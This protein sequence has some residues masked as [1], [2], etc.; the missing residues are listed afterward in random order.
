MI[1]KA[2]NILAPEIPTKLICFSDDMDALRKVPSNLPNQEVLHKSI[3]LSLTKVPD[4]YGTASSFGANMNKRLIAFLTKFNF[5]FEFASSSQYYN[6]G[7]FNDTLEK[8]LLNYEEINNLIKNTLGTERREEYS[9]FMPICPASG[10]VLEKGVISVNKDNKTVKFYD[11]NDQIQECYVG[12]GNCKLQW[13]AD[14]GMRWSALEVNYEMYG[15]DLISSADLASKLCK[16]IGSKSPVTYHY[17]LFLDDAGQKI[18]KS[19]GN[20]LTMEEWLRYAP[21]E[22]LSY[23]MY[24][25]PKSAKR[26]FF[27]VIPKATDEYLTF[28]K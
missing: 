18:S 2:F 9:I 3:G 15:K 24:L 10:K 11:S 12:N 5:D 6:N 20:G 1:I 21:H 23:Y 25:K 28:F 4:P 19:K 13:K 16:I 17:E 26:L 14:F 7:K 27:D 22:S 8:I